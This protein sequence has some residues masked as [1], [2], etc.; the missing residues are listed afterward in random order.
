MKLRFKGSDA[1]GTRAAMD[2]V[3]MGTTHGSWNWSQML[4][5]GCTM[6]AYLPEA[7]NLQSMRPEA[8]RAVIDCAEGSEGHYTS[9]MTASSGK[10]GFLGT[11]GP[12][13]ITDINS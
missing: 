9:I 4:R 5:V 11:Y 1:P 8:Y 2:Y 3:I 6:P 7:T 10:S 13:L 12:Y